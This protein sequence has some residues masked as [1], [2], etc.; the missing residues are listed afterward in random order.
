MPKVTAHFPWTDKELDGRVKRAIKGNVG[1]A[2]RSA[3]E[4][5]RVGST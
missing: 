1:H 2:R 4:T 5:T 3:A